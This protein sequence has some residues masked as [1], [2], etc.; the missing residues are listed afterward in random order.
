MRK[1]VHHA[2]YQ[3][4]VEGLVEARRNSGMTQVEVA[5][6]LHRPQSYISKYEKC[7]RRLDVIEMLEIVEVIKADPVT[8]IQIALNALRAKVD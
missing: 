4:L 6:A 7:E 5:N 8:L 1:S 2:A 3:K